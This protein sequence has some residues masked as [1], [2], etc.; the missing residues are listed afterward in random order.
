MGDYLFQFR[1]PIHGFIDVTEDEKKIINSEAFQRLRSIRQLG[2][3]YLVYHG[4]EHTRFG[5]SLGVMHLASRVFDVITDKQPDLFD[6]PTRE[7]YR[8]ILRLIGLTHDLGHAPFSHASEHLFDK[9]FEHEDMTREILFKTEIAGYIREIGKKLSEE[10]REK[11]G[12]MPSEKCTITPELIWLIYE[13]ED[14][15]ND[16]YIMPDFKFLKSFMDGEL[17][18]DKM[19][20]LLRDSY[21]CG[22]KYGHYDLDRLV[23]SLN[24]YQKIDENIL[25]LA[26]EYGGI[27]ALEEFVLARYFMFIQ[28]YF[29]K[30]RRYLDKKLSDCL[31]RLLPNGKYPSDV[32]EYLSWNDDKVLDLIQQNKGKCGHA[33]AFANREVLTCIY[34]ANVHVSSDGERLFKSHCRSLEEKILDKGIDKEE[35]SRYYYKDETN[36]AAHKIADKINGD[37]VAIPILVEHQ[38]EPSSVYEKSLLLRSLIEPI[39]IRRIYVHNDFKQIAEDIIDI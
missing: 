8:Q 33:R 26:L 17:D 2:T 25:L 34:Q 28:V 4:A 7:K 9:G 12:I 35:L 14:V 31:E 11:Y 39:T 10:H 30:T 20:Y 15:L 3:S 16:A 27:H 37:E 18:C 19:D 32:D 36:K 22:V 29:H 1:D 6:K 21:Y 5:H 13:G 24:I 23:S 38:K